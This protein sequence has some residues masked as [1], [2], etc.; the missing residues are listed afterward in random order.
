MLRKKSFALALC[1]V[2][3]LSCSA[4]ASLRV[5]AL[6]KLN[7]GDEEFSIFQRSASMWGNLPGNHGKDDVIVFYDSIMTML[8]SLGGG[9]LDE[10]DLP[11]IVGA[12]VLNSRPDYKISCVVR[13]K[14]EYLAFGFLKDK[15][16][17]LRDKFNEAL[18]AIKEDG[19]LAALIAH[20]MKV[21]GEAEA[22][23]FERFAAAETVRVAVTGDLP[24]IDYVSTEGKA[25]GF[26][27]ALLAEIA[28]RL[29]INIKL[30]YVNSGARTAALTS[31]RAD[32]VFWYQL[33]EGSAKQFDVPD[34]VIV[35]DPYYDWNTFVHI[36]Q[37]NTYN[38]D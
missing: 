34:S 14:P 37:K 33:T 15:N 12:Y 13:T 31:G 25:A 18:K 3:T 23:N 29:K 2:L 28:K 17:T 7:V 24:P 11:G 35:S 22:V 32:V 5:G 21:D 27:T 30:T 36:S 16:E 19:T 4:F 8:M 9:D 6:S 10:V 26:N 38:D 20:Y 1:F